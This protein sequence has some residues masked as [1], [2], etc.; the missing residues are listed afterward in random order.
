MNFCLTLGDV[1]TI[2]LSSSKSKT[3][4]DQGMDYEV[5]IDESV[6]S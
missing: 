4:V 2:E 1:F 6:E 5:F 3:V